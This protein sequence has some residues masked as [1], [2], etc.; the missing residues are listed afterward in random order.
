MRQPTSGGREHEKE[1][2]QRLG[3]VSEEAFGRE[4]QAGEDEQ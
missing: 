1:H 4:E 3:G 2:G